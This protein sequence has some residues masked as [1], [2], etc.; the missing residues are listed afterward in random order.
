MPASPASVRP[1]SRS[2]SS[3]SLCGFAAV[4]A[5]SGL[6]N[7][8]VAFSPDVARYLVPFG[9]AL[10]LFTYAFLAGF[11]LTR[12]IHRAATGHPL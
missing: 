4:R 8:A 1:A 3:I 5:I 9:I 7:A 12:L 6:T 10:P 2:P 11:W